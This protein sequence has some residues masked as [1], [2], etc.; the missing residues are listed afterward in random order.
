MTTHAL[1]FD[2]LDPAREVDPCPKDL[3]SVLNKLR[4]LMVTCRA[5]PRL[6]LMSACAV[7]S[8]EGEVAARRYADTLLRTLRDVLG[9][10]PI[11]H[12]PGTE[13]VSFD[14]AWLIR[15]ID[16][17]KQGDEASMAFL[18]CRRVPRAQRSGVGFLVRG[19]AREI[20]SL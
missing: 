1:A 2:T 15:M 12:A 18:L 5:A 3:V 8:M 17:I 11:L 9:R 19:L 7:L 4:F 13:G 6:D 20:E 14:E 10:A 16:R